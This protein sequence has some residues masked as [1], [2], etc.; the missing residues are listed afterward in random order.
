[1]CSVWLIPISYYYNSR[2]QN[3]RTWLR[4]ASWNPVFS[5]WLNNNGKYNVNS[6]VNIFTFLWKALRNHDISVTMFHQVVDYCSSVV[7]YSYSLCQGCDSDS[8]RA[9]RSRD[10]IQ[11]GSDF[12]HPSKPTLG[13]TQSP[14][15]LVLGLLPG[16]KAA[17]EWWWPLTLI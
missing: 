4:M 7:L 17:L 10:R 12:P 8:L 6:C 15:Q 14:A 13:P 1:M 16:Y 3:K 5:V 9:R 2:I 11:V